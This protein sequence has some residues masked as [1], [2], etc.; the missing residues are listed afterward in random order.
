MDEQN[1]KN[2]PTNQDFLYAY[3][4]TLYKS[5]EN[6]ELEK[7]FSKFL[8]K[9]YNF[10]FWNLYIEYVNKV[11]TK[12]VNLIDVYSFV[13]AHFDCSYFSYEYI[14]NYI[15][16]LVTSDEDGSKIDLIRK[17][18]QK[19]MIP[20]HNLG[21][22]WSEYEK[23]EIRTNKLT[24]KSIIDAIQPVYNLSFNTYQR[25]LPFIESNQFFKIFD[26]ELENPLKLQK[27]AHD[28]RLN[29]LFNFYIN[30]F[31]LS[32]PLQFLYS[33][34]L[35]D[36]AKEKF[37]SDRSSANPL[38]ISS[39]LSI[40]YSFLFNSEYFN[41]QDIKNKDLILI[42]YLNFTLKN[43][44]IEKF[45]EKFVENKINAGNHVYIYMA[46]SEFYQGGNKEGAYQIFIEATEKFKND[47]LVNEQFFR[48]FLNIGDD[49]NIRRLFKK[50]VKT[51]NMWDLMIE[52]EFLH[53]ELEDYKNLLVQKQID[54]GNK[55]ILQSVVT[56]SFKI[57]NKGTQGI[58]ETAF[59]SFGFLDLQ[60]ATNDVLSDFVSK[61]PE[62]DIREN[63][64]SN[65][66]NQKIV[67][68]LSML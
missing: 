56:T 30:K 38:Q 3:A 16:E 40:W 31:P 64:L 46:K 25:L 10:N 65:L 1:F 51:E 39:F 49:D 21:L 22:L 33:F 29:F 28:A 42:N 35:K 44:G 58:Y 11:S 13:V 15:R 18:Y 50:L 55:E 8:K 47:P 6:K 36:L 66:D 32:S 53:G 41:F 37:L 20:M 48:M 60:L 68:L 67:D 54:L 23:W 24:S 52:Y 19:S 4:L 26:I 43:E 7:L 45:R 14:S 34:Y 59:K 5:G 63:V 61:L 2:N 12:K 17:I 62:L 9:S 57:K 27:K